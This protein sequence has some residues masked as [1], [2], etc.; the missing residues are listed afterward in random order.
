MFGFL[1]VKNIPYIA[2]ALLVLGMLAYIGVQYIQIANRDTI[3]SSQNATIANMQENCTMQETQIGLLQDDQ[4]KKKIALAALEKQVK[5]QEHDINTYRERIGE[6]QALI[7]GMTSTPAAPLQQKGEVLDNE[8]SIRAVAYINRILH[9]L[10]VR[11]HTDSPAGDAYRG[12][13]GVH[14]VPAAGNAQPH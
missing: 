1:T 11:F 7:A 4:G 5:D 14:A 13:T 2:A 12:A 6:Q 8:S 3:I 9:A 10:R